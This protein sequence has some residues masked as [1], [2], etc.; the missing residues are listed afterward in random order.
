MWLD[1]K[2]TP[3]QICGVCRNESHK[4]DASGTHALQG[5]HTASVESGHLAERWR[6]GES[7]WVKLSGAA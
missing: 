5:F 4:V 7:P 6:S 1:I 3:L 2:I